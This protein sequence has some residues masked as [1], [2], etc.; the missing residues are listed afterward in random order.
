MVDNYR[1]IGHFYD[2]LSHLYG[3]RA[4][5]RCKLAML[6]QLR[7]GDKVLFAGVGHGLDAIYA[8][9]RGAQV[10]VVDLSQTMLD[11]FQDNLF[12]YQI[13]QPIR[14]VHGDILAFREY[15]QY[16]VVVANFFLNVFDEASMPRV[17]AHLIDLGKADAR[18]VVGDFCPANGGWLTRAMQAVYWYTAVLL[19]CVLTDNPLHRIYHYPTHLQALGL[20]VLDTRRFGSRGHYWAILAQK[21]G[22]RR[23]LQPERL[24]PLPALAEPA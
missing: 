21:H 23:P 10:T 16:D 18:V 2:A 8:A 1:L 5:Q 22:A 15:E 7:P 20:S 24:P 19:F 9:E 14:Q 12:R 4:L 17:L 13:A 3:G 6:D 11:K